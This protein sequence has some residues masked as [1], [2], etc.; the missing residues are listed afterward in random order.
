MATTLLLGESGTGKELLA[1]AVHAL[2][3]R[4]EGPFVAINCAA[5]PDALLESEL[6]GHERGAFTGAVKQTAGKFELANGGTLF[7]DE[8]GDM[9]LQLQAKLLRFLQERVIERVGGRESIPIDVR[10]VCATN[11]DLEQL[12][13]RNEFREDLYYRISEVTL[14]IPPLRE[15]P[16]DAVVIGQAIMERRAR[17]HGRAVRGF[18]PEAIQ[19]IQAYPWPGNIR[20]LENRINGAVIMAEGRYIGVEELGLPADAAEFKWLNLREVRQRAESEAVR[21]ALAVTQGNLSRSA[22]LLGVTRPTLYDLIEK[23]GID[24]AERDSAAQRAAPAA[25]S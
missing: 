6:F 4:A 15:R 16:G 21:Q 14:R 24:T 2:S 22:E 23:L 25:E 11:K 20:E 13:K 7:L 19:A 12:I 8:I 1:R 9:T 18:T 17:E 3:T 10:I 5:I